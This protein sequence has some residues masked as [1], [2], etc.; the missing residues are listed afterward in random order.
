MPIKKV[1]LV[2]GVLGLMACRPTERMG[3]IAPD[4]APY[5]IKTES[6]S[7]L[8]VEEPA[9]P[10]AAQPTEQSAEPL[11]NPKQAGWN[12]D[13]TV[14]DKCFMLLAYDPEDTSVNLRDQPDG[15]VLTSLPNLT[16]VHSGQPAYIEPGWNSL[17]V[18]GQDQQGYIWQDLLRLTYYQVE[19]PQD[20]YANLR[21]SPGGPVI[22]TLD[23]GT[24]VRFLGEDGTWTQVELASGQVGYVATS[25]LMRPN[26]F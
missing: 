22:N 16:R 23:N 17:S 15:S 6:V 8:S 14:T 9:E 25:L 11:T 18:E 4:P 20:T 12:P 2:F 5:T 3:E 10:I 7:P 21:Q 26:C 1:Y 13:D 19:D 24:E